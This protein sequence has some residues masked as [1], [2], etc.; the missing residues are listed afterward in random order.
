MIDRKTV[1]VDLDNVVYPLVEV[2]AHL[3]VR[4][5]LASSFPEELIGLYKSWNLWDDWQIPKGAFDF[6]WEK[7]IADGEMWGVTPSVA[8]YPLARAARG[9]WTLSDNEWHIH[10]VTHRLNKTRLHD[11]AIR[12]TAD[13]LKWANIPYRSLTFTEDKHALTGD[14]I[15]DDNPNNL[16]RHPAPT[17]I[18]YPAPHNKDFNPDGYGIT[19]LLEAEGVYP[20]DEIA[21]MLGDG[22]RS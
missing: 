14:V 11:T 3:V 20:W 5:G 1:L 7:A 2:M 4:E 18:L 12:S 6:V 9:L 10:L 19:T 17:K 16:I 21:E 13:W 22:V 8:P 15:I